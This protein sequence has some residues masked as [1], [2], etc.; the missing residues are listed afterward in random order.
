LHYTR[1]FM[2]LTL[3]PSDV[4]MIHRAACSLAWKGQFEGKEGYPMIRLEAV[5]GYN[6]WFWHSVFGFAGKPNDINIWDRSKFYESLLDVT[7]DDIDH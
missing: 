3:V 6:L 4:T 1:E 5:A 2:A 7:H